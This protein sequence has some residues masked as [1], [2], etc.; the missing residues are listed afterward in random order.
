MSARLLVVDD[1][2]YLRATL[3][4]M[5]R[6]LGYDVV[7]A[8]DAHSAYHLL[9]GDRFD[10]ILLDIRLPQMRGDTFYLT[11]VRQWPYLA[12]RVVLMTGDPWSVRD[13]WSDELRACPMLPKPFLF[14][15]LRDTIAA[16]IGGTDQR[17]QSSEG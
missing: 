6:R 5:L 8:A 11:A 12:G 4:K 2:P 7:L 9:A 3:D 10:A 1:E 17:R 15:S 13:Q 16:A 14:E